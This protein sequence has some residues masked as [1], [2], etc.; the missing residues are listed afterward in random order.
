MKRSLW[1]ALLCGLSTRAFA[2]DITLDFNV[3]G[4]NQKFILTAKTNLPVRTILMANVANPMNRGGDGYG[5]STEA[6]VLAN[7]T[8]AFGPFTKTKDRFVPGTYKVAVTTVMAALQPEEVQPFFGEH[9]ERLTG[10]QVLTLPGTSERIVSQT[11]Q[12]KINQDGSLDSPM[13]SEHQTGDGL[14]GG[15]PDDI[16]QKVQSDGREISVMMNGRYYAKG[17]PSGHTFQSA[18]GKTSYGW[19]TPTTPLV[20]GFRTYIVA[21]LPE[22]TIVGAPQS[23]MHEVEGN[24]EARHYSVLGSLFFSGKNRSGVAMQDMPPENIERTL[25]P[26]S[27]FEKAF[28]TLC[29][30]ARE[31]K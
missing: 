22:S 28:D 19:D 26:N 23:V 21:N 31:Q 17:F 16:W 12:F 15:S 6:A 29:K 8:V 2:A 5:G 11:F 30:I 9:G 24:C 1:I 18:D 20:Y 13:P 27:P 4:N 10:R 25:V 3:T 14:A 7:Q